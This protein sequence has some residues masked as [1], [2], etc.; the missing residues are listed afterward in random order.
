MGACGENLCL[1]KAGADLSTNCFWGEFVQVAQ[2]VDIPRNDGR[3]TVREV[4][5]GRPSNDRAG[6]GVRHIAL[7]E[8]ATF[9][10]ALGFRHSPDCCVERLR[11]NDD[12]GSLSDAILDAAPKVSIPFEPGPSFDEIPILE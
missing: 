6:T 7:V 4:C 2:G 10:P 1:P 5:Q 9:D 8:I 11:V 12:Y 3:E